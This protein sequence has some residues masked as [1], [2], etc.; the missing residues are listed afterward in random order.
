MQRIESPTC[1]LGLLCRRV[2]N[3]ELVH[4]LHRSLSQQQ[5]LHHPLQP[6]WI[7]AVGPAR[8]SKA[9]PSFEEAV[10]LPSSLVDEWRLTPQWAPLLAPA[11]IRLTPNALVLD[12]TEWVRTITVRQLPRFVQPGW[13]RPLMMLDEPLDLSLSY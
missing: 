10:R 3:P 12:E 13:L 9:P 8:P 4:L 6:E 1:G 2:R 11:G 5:A 7:E